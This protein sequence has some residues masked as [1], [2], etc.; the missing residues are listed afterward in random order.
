M[1]AKSSILEL[2]ESISV[3]D[4]VN[5]MQD[6]VRCTE[7]LL[8]EVIQRFCQGAFSVVLLNNDATKNEDGEIGVN[9]RQV[10]VPGFIK[11]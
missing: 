4:Y 9:H 1:R 10:V 11:V 7:H 3:A 2:L 8:L 6:N 5:G